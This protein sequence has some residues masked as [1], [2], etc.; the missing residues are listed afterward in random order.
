MESWSPYGWWQHLRAHLLQVSKD[1]WWKQLFDII[2]AED[3]HLKK[4]TQRTSRN[5]IMSAGHQRT[6][7]SYL[8]VGNMEP[9]K[10]SKCLLI[11]YI[12]NWEAR[13]WELPPSICGSFPSAG[14]ER[15]TSCS[16]KVTNRLGSSVNITGFFPNIIPLIFFVCLFIFLLL[17]L[18]NEEK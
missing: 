11:W 14:F 3:R 16:E 13:Q 8:W 12:L 18:E 2:S 4:F 9:R 17:L 15:N 5:N 7:N 1:Y 6:H 10:V